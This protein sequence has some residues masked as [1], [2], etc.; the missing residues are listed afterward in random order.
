VDVFVT[1]DGKVDVL[2]TGRRDRPD[3]A[4]LFKVPDY[5]SSGFS[6]SI[7]VDGLAKG[8]HTLSLKVLRD[9]KK[10]YFL[11]SQQVEL[12]VRYPRVATIRRKSSGGMFGTRARNSLSPG[13]TACA[14]SHMRSPAI[15][16]TSCSAGSA[17][18]SFSKRCWAALLVS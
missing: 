2:A 15:Q 16:E 12:E 11:S 18:T 5:R 13:P 1:I 17:A 7:L 14:Y 3:I 6:G 10:E 4:A 9:N 8:K